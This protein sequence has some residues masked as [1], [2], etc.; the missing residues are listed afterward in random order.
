MSVV[1][2]VAIFLDLY[3]NRFAFDLIFF[4]IPTSRIQIVQWQLALASRWLESCGVIIIHFDVH[5]QNEKYER[6]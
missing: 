4:A 3:S 5:R 2:N 6:A 1:V